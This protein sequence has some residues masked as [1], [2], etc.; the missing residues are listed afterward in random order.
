MVVN[1][2]KRILGLILIVTMITAY[3]G[4]SECSPIYAE[5]VY[6]VTFNVE[7][8]QSEAR[9]MLDSINELR[10]G[11]DAWYWNQ[12]NSEKIVCTDL[13]PLVYDYELEKI[14]MLRAA[15]IAF[16]YSH[17]RPNGESCFSAN[18]YRGQE[19]LGENIAAW[20]YSAD[21]VF[22]DWKEDYEPYKGQGHRRN[23]LS[24]HYKTV[25]IG[26]V[27]VDG[28]HY[29]TQEFGSIVR[30][31][32]ETPASNKKEKIDSQVLSANVESVTVSVNSITVAE[33]E[34]KKAPSV[35]LKSNVNWTVAV[36]AQCEWQTT[37]DKCRT[38]GYEIVGLEAGKTRLTTVFNKGTV[39]V[40]VVSNGDSDN[41]DSEEDG[42]LYE[43]TIKSLKSG[44]NCITVKWTDSKNYDI[45]G[46][47]VQYS[48]DKTFKS[49][50]TKTKY[51]SAVED[52]EDYSLKITKLTAGKTY[53]VRIRAVDEISDNE[54][55][56][57]DWSEV[58][59]VKVKTPKD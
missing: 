30:N 34:K 6:D 21:E 28:R 2:K 27:V 40:E 5:S 16:Y 52:K 41:N 17:T 18:P 12:D 46:Y 53:Y 42:S 33:G 14:A 13:E 54:K 15:E 26:H 35:A 39:D 48:K 4:I 55:E 10:T 1:M 57:S 51:V 24:E 32:E 44:T 58:K 45:S 47:E 23:M 56:W 37:D 25:G 29:W 8:G 43:T 49:K 7:F 50:S 38:E 19:W 11:E 20:Q 59:K 9:G 22:F 31:D 3:I 36:E